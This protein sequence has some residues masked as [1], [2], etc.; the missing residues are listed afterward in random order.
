MRNVLKDPNKTYQ[1]IHPYKQ[2]HRFMA[3][4]LLCSLLLQSCGGGYQLSVISDNDCR[5]GIQHLGHSAPYPAGNEGTSAIARRNYERPASP[6]ARPQPT[7]LRAE[8]QAGTTYPTRAVAH[9]VPNNPPKASRILSSARGIGQYWKPVALLAAVAAGASQLTGQVGSDAVRQL[10]SMLSFP[11]VSALPMVFQDEDLPLQD[12]DVT[13]NDVSHLVSGEAPQLGRRLLQSDGPDSDSYW[14][15]EWNIDGTNLLTAY[16]KQKDYAY[17]AGINFNSKS[18]SLLKNIFLITI[19]PKNHRSYGIKTWSYHNSTYK[20]F[21]IELCNEGAYSIWKNDY[22]SNTVVQKTSYH[23]ELLWE[24]TIGDFSPRISFVDSNDMI[25]I[26]GI[27][28]G[29]ETSDTDPQP[30]ATT[31]LLKFRTNGSLAFQQ[32]YGNFHFKSISTAGSSNPIYILGYY[33]SYDAATRQCLV[34]K[35][36]NNGTYLW[37]KALEKGNSTFDCHADFPTLPTNAQSTI[38]SNGALYISLN[39]KIIPPSE[40]LPNEKNEADAILIVQLDGNGELLQTSTLLKD[41]PTENIALL[42]LLT[43]S[44]GALYGIGST[45]NSETVATGLA[46][47]F[48][49]NLTVEWAKIINASPYIGIASGS[50]QNNEALYM[51]G[52][53]QVRNAPSAL[54][55]K[56]SATP[57]VCSGFEEIDNS[58]KVIKEPLTI[59]LVN[60]S[61]FT[62]PSVPKRNISTNSLLGVLKPYTTEIDIEND[63]IGYS[64]S[65]IKKIIPPFSIPAQRNI[66]VLSNDS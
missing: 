27:T 21:S 31:F 49:R 17:A 43:D 1:A 65:N 12:A 42:S 29:K 19:D 36:N 61:L 14:T 60:T 23:G 54:I 20:P 48:G 39:E 24:K 41:E 52:Y 11:Q 50:I 37:V 33:A 35:L 18:T 64:R 46:L 16:K 59:V 63:R 58:F 44:S 4:I 66:P 3:T 62:L 30:I 28:G 10:D 22:I 47:K 13:V 8:Q 5:D 40:D 9:A 25:Y 32:S 34:A 51:L 45:S 15:K 57:G 53:K 2:G 55:V 26:N 7:H 38:D 56:T 6:A